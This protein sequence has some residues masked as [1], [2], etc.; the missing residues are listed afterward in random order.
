MKR[1]LS[2]L[3]IVVTLLVFSS[4]GGNKNSNL[5]VEDIHAVCELATIKCYY[6]N[7]GQVVKEKDNFL[8]KDRKMWIEYEGE[9]VIG[10]NISK[11]DIKIKDD[12]VTIVMPKAEVL[13]ISPKKET[14]NEKSCIA[15]EDGFLF[16]NKITTEV[17][18]QAIVQGQVKIQEAVAGNTALFVKAETKAKELIGNYIDKLGNVIGKEYTIHWEQAE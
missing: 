9:A 7:V 8:Q 18:E 3:L 4:C 12:V 6:N 15:T 2:L 14:L 16:K 17:Q 5:K 1:V 10:V 11:M 13:S